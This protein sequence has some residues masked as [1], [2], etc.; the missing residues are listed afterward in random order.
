MVERRHRSRRKTQTCRLWLPPSPNC[1]RRKTS[2][3]KRRTSCWLNWQ[4]RRPLKV[5]D[6]EWMTLLALSCC[7]Y[8]M[9]VK[10]APETIKFCSPVARSLS[11]SVWSAPE[12]IKQATKAPIVCDPDWHLFNDSCYFISRTS[13]DWPESK[14]YCES[15]GAH[16]A[17]IHTAEEQVHYDKLTYHNAFSL[18]CLLTTDKNIVEYHYSLQKHNYWT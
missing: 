18:F 11:L 6:F 12:V 3:R 9:R 1:S 16:L 8:C 15:Q 14:S 7:C 17:I 2:C 10:C 13:R 4:P 5:D